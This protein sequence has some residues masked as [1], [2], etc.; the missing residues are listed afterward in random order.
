MAYPVVTRR[1]D[2]RAKI[3]Y[4]VQV[5]APSAGHQDY[6]QDHHFPDNLPKVWDRV[7][8]LAFSTPCRALAVLRPLLG[9]SMHSCSPC[10]H[11][12]AHQL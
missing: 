9:R 1:V 11:L 8:P 2:P 7:S 6:F 3:I 4:A 5:H 12:A 10:I